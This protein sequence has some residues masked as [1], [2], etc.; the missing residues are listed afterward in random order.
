MMLFSEKM[1]DEGMHVLEVNNFK[2]SAYRESNLNWRLLKGYELSGN[3]KGCIDF[4][5]ELVNQSNS[6]SPLFHSLSLDALISASCKLKQPA[7]VHRY[8]KLA[9]TAGLHVESSSIDRIIRYLV[10]SDDWKKVYDR[11]VANHTSDQQDECALEGE[12]TR[13]NLFLLWKARTC[14]LDRAMQFILERYFRKDGLFFYA[15]GKTISLI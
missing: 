15:E 14:L 7:E 9:E 1:Y 2:A 5:N 8:F 13:R 6:P 4:A 11:M 12:M 3:A 10:T